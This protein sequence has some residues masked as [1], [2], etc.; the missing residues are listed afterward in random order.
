MFSIQSAW[1]AHKNVC[2]LIHLKLH[3]QSGLHRYSH[4]SENR[5]FP[6]EKSELGR[7]LLVCFACLFAC[8]SLFARECDLFVLLACNGLLCL[9]TNENLFKK[10]ETSLES[11]IQKI[12][13]EKN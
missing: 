7:F 12:I 6:F 11:I 13:N 5:E 10:P 2:Y 8:S 4:Q 3:V 9:F 1:L